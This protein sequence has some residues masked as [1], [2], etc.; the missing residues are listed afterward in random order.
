MAT[1]MPGRA[2]TTGYGR[3]GSWCGG[4]HGGV[5][6]AAPTG[7][8]VLA[9]WSGTV[10]GRTWGSSFGTQI[11]I[12]QDRLPDGRAGM[13]A[14]YAHLSRRIVSPGHRVTVGQKIGE[15]G[16]TGNATG[17][18]LHYEVQPQGAW[19]CGAGVDPQPWLDAGTQAPAPPQQPEE[20]D[21]VVIMINY[22]GDR[23]AAYP[24]AGT[25]RRIANPAQESAIRSIIGKSGGRVVEWAAGEDVDDL[26]AFGVTIG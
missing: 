9:A 26:D 21:M 22:K 11:V 13:F 20:D 12:D 5:D 4:R 7:T 3:P 15:V 10:T 23:F 17:P 1:P 19:K 18:H 25:K 8:P 6:F 16:A 14:V 24:A 2:V